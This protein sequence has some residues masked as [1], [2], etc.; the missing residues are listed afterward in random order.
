MAAVEEREYLL[1]S[2]LVRGSVSDMDINK[3]IEK[4]FGL[5]TE[6]GKTV[7]PTPILHSILNRR[8]IREFSNTPVN[9]DVMKTLLAAA[10][11]APSKSD[12]QQA[13]FMGD[14]IKSQG[15]NFE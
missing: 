4:R 14:F 7:E 11:S 15:F 9:E 10:F 8:S 3:A 12:L 6:V 13:R 5:P 1:K 2:G